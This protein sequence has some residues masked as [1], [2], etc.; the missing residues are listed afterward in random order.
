MN[1]LLELIYELYVN[2][3]YKHEKNNFQLY[4]VIE[5][6]NQKPITIKSRKKVNRKN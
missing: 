6:A 5:K 1:L 3:V 2:L 4:I